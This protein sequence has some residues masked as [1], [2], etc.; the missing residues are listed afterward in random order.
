MLVFDK[1]ENSKTRTKKSSLKNANA[2]I[3]TQKYLYLISVPI[4]KYKCLK[5]LKILKKNPKTFDP[6]II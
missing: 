1:N 3:M 5:Y 4:Y 2:C 6:K